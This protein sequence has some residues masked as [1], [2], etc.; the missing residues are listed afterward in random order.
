MNLIDH[1]LNRIT[2]YKLI[3][4]VLIALLFTAEL[5]SIF[6]FLPFS[7]IHLAWSI[8]LITAISLASNRIFAY[9]FDAPSNPESTY[10]TAL[11]LALII[12]PPSLFLDVH[13]LSLI[14]WATTWAIASKY[15]FAFGN[16]HLFN[17]AAF[18]VATTAFF[19][20]QSATWWIATNT[21]IPFILI[22]GFLIT[23]KIKRFDLVIPF[24]I[25]SSLAIL[26]PALA[27][28]VGIIPSI[29]R[30]F[31]LT[32]TVFL[33]TVMLTEPITTPPTRAKRMLY[34]GIVGALFFPGI[35][36]FGLYATPE[37]ALLAG[38]LFSYLTSPKTR[39]TLTLT[40]RIRLTND[41]YEFIFTSK[42]QITFSPGQYL[43]WTLP[44]DNHDN[45]G[46]R[47]FFTIASAPTKHEVRLS[48]KFYKPAS[49]FK[50]TLLSM[51]NGD[52]V[53]AS[54]P[55]GDFVMPKDTQ[56]KLVFIAGGIGI[57]PFVSMVRGMIAENKSR[58]IVLL[59]V[60]KT[61]KDVAYGDTLNTATTNG[62]RT[63]YIFSDKPNNLTGDATINADVIRLQIPDFQERVF[64]ISGP[65]NMV[66]NIAI[67]LRTLD[68][69]SSRTKVDYF[70]GFA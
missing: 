64:Y 22:G 5:S 18:G 59:Y 15:I 44:H 49:T 60:N 26:I 63:I 6:G 16:K 21:M 37:L 53:I 20:G 31:V 24:L 47:R 43:E 27:H 34:G 58:D 1:L 10:I 23:R 69:P 14:F 7:S 61:A 39:P 68:I 13:S 66:A 70:P 17:P 46:I 38:N 55:S 65:H 52:T 30:A 32:P 50:K 54:Q 42:H 40:K 36:I 3:L 4:Y 25:T 56:K 57:T 33:A 41:V 51:H 8:V 45:R 9:L 67:V 2:M 62:V 19:L 12:S 29:M 28:G 35:N 11:I 48:T